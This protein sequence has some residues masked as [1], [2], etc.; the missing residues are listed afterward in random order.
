MAKTQST[1]RGDTI[2]MRMENGVEWS[3]GRRQMDKAEREAKMGI[4]SQEPVTWF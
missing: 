1:F 4:G 2:W 3:F